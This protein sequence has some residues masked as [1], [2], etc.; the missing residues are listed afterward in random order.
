MLAAVKPVGSEFYMED[1]FAAGGI[2][3]VLRELKPL[4]NLDCLT[5]TGE[6]LRERLAAEE[7]DYVDRRVIKSAKE[8]LEPHG[9]L[10]ALF[11]SLA[12]DGAIIKRS[13]AT[14]SLFE[15][16]GRAVVFSSLDDLGARI[17]DPK[18]DVTADD[19][20]IL[21]NAGPRSAS[22]MPEAGF[23]PI[24]KKLLEA[25]VKDMVRMSDA[26]MSGTA[27]G[28]IILHIAPEAA[29]GGPLA[30]VRTGDKIRLS[31]EGTDARSAGGREGTRRA[32][33]GGQ[34]GRARPRP[35]LRQAVPG[36]RHAGAGRVRLRVSGAVTSPSPKRRGSEAAEYR[37]WHAAA[38]TRPLR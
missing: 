13:A 30:L 2:G 16:T 22:A 34:A 8:P 11:G 35:R 21:Q 14:P 9:G 26:R 18:L 31:R 5:V 6:T 3:A 23:L 24:P 1:F 32:P 12:P 19:F 7:G 33:Q 10:V 20:L 4:L 17:D 36:Q 25:G 37:R 38:L 15:K 27:Y 28:T 29:V